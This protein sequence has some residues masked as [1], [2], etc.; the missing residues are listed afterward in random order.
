MS[1]CPYLHVTAVNALLW[2]YDT[3]RNKV[4]ITLAVNG[5]AVVRRRDVG[6]A[7]SPK[8]RLLLLQFCPIDST[9]FL[10]LRLL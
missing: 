1:A 4:A 10:P 9:R 6:M 3:A 7:A 8:I 5:K 2:S